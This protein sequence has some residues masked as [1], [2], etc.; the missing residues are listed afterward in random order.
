MLTPKGEVN[1]LHALWDSTIYEF[2]KDFQQP[3]SEESW[4]ALG[5]ISETVRTEHPVTEEQMKM[6]LLKPEKEWADE[7]FK[8]ATEV[9][10]NIEQ[11]TLPDEEYVKVA[12]AVVH[13][14]LAKGGYRL[15]QMLIDIFDKKTDTPV[16]D[17]IKFLQ[18]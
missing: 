10:Y 14:Q 7:G 16:Q 15:A 8:L 13:R 12:R 17:T 18:N 11:N 9:V 1:E 2:D 6:E 3:L 5:N 4:E